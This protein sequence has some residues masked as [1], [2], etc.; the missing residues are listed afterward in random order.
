MWFWYQYYWSWIFKNRNP[1][2]KKPSL[3]DLYLAHSMLSSCQE[4]YIRHML[5]DD[6][7]NNDNDPRNKLSSC[8]SVVF[9]IRCFWNVHSTP[10][11]HGENIQY[12]FWKT[13][14]FETIKYPRYHISI[15][16]ATLFMGKERRF[17]NIFYVSYFPNN[18][19]WSPLE[20]RL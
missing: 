5:S 12:W 16:V 9:L 6:F 11:E 3:R 10:T 15:I 4:A 14:A 8:K 17:Y 13:L 7:E 2:R 18:S 19:Y 1:Q 20:H